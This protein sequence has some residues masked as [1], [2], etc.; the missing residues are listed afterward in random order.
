MKKF[1]GPFTF[2]NFSSFFLRSLDLHRSVVYPCLSSSSDDHP[3][4]HSCLGTGMRVGSQKQVCHFLA[5]LV[6]SAST[7]VFT[8]LSVC[9]WGSI[10]IL[11]LL[12]HFI[13]TFATVTTPVLGALVNTLQ[14]HDTVDFEQA[15]ETEDPQVSKTHGRGR[16]KKL[17]NLRSVTWL[18]H[19]ADSI[20]LE[21]WKWKMA[22]GSDL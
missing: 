15:S 19:R 9:W 2:E 13:R 1:Y 5:S 4:L 8:S 17:S 6:H 20:Q 22:G 21:T 7:I 16:K 12:V 14:Y 18:S 10:T 11:L 3:L